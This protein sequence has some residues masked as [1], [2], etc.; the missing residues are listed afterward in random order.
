[1][2]GILAALIAFLAG[3]FSGLLGIGGG[4]S[5]EI[6]LVDQGDGQAAQGRIPRH[7]G[8]IDAPADHD[9]IK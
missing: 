8:P 4:G 5:P 7:T 3:I 1:M 6:V 9:E 2:I